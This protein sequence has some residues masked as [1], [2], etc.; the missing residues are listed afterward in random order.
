LRSL[1][2]EWGGRAL[3]ELVMNIKRIA[4]TARLRDIPSPPRGLTNR[5]Q[6]RD[7]ETLSFAELEHAGIE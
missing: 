3:V 4:E 5:G 6:S 1:Y 2:R 7:R